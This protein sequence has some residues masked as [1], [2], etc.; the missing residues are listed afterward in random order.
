MF[1][2]LTIKMY[3]KRIPWNLECYPYFDRD[4]IARVP[5]VLAAIKDLQ[6][7]APFEHTSLLDVVGDYGLIQRGTRVIRLLSA[8]PDNQL[9][10]L[11]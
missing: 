5:K 9:T 8:S 7:Y 11:R 1:E 4:I 3:N 10:S 2:V 6:I